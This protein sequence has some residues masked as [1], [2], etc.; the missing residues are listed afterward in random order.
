M[1][2]IG[3]DEVHEHGLSCVACLWAE[4]LLFHARKHFVAHEMMRKYAPPMAFGVPSLLPGFLVLLPTI[5]D[6]LRPLVWGA[7]EA[8]AYPQWAPPAR[9]GDWRKLAPHE[10]KGA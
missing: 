3:L 4:K 7:A 5:A 10:K 8:R 1:D 9:G 2:A 6:A